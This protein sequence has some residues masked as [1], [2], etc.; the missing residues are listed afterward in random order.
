MTRP[1][2]TG[3]ALLVVLLFLAVLLSMLGLTQR[4]LASALSIESVRRHSQ[5]RDSGSVYAAAL[6]V[7]LLETGLPPES[8]YSC[9]VTMSTVTG[10]RTYAVIFVQGTAVWTVTVRPAEAFEVL[11]PMPASFAN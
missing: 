3:Y 4:H 5:Q 7:E 8:P 6:A 11:D 10:P 1:R 9:G 2:R